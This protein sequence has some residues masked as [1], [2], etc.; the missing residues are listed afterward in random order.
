MIHRKRQSLEWLISKVF[1]IAQVF[2]QKL[3]G[4][5]A[6]TV[7]AQAIMRTLH[8]GKKCKQNC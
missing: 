4:T 1:Q 7:P 6:P 8:G 5:A 2:T 3:V